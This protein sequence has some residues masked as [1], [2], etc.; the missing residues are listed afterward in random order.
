VHT[1]APCERLYQRHARKHFLKMFPLI[2][3]LRPK[4]RYWI[5]RM[6]PKLHYWIIRMHPKL[7]YWIIR[8]RP[9]LH[10]WFIR[11]RTKLILV[12]KKDISVHTHIGVMHV[13]IDW[14]KSG[15]NR[16]NTIAN[17]LGAAYLT[18]ALSF[19]HNGIALC[20]ANCRWHP[21]LSLSPTH[22]LVSL[23]L[24]LSL[25]DTV[26]TFTHYQRKPCTTPPP[27][28]TPIRRLTRDSRVSP[29]KN[30]RGTLEIPARS[31]LVN[32]LALSPCSL[33]ITALPFSRFLYCH[34]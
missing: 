28:P 12:I 18:T 19:A 33:T 16:R 8:M 24:S 32:Q 3:K 25:S 14:A 21:S 34:M 7:H 4:L 2:I 29:D 22:T 1:S 5:I 30:V 15:R 6:H 13:H 26:L 20:Y 17:Y 31:F 9:K 23:S 27:P 10:Y 11:M